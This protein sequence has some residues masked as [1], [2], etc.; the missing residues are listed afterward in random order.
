M[1]SSRSGNHSFSRDN[2]PSSFKKSSNK[3]T[4]SDDDN[5]SNNSYNRS[6]NTSSNNS[7]TPFHVV[8]SFIQRLLQLL[9]NSDN[10]S[11]Y[12]ISSSQ[13]S[14]TQLPLPHL[15][16]LKNHFHIIHPLHLLIYLSPT[17][18]LR[19]SSPPH[20]C[21]RDQVYN[22][23]YTR[24]CASGGGKPARLYLID[25]ARNADRQDRVLEG[26]KEVKGKREKKV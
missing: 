5:Y 2:S 10:K 20:P 23:A 11:P 24:A 18:Q 15:Q 6:F 8:Y 21:F 14:S 12:S 25:W 22:A 7:R 1:S 17:R 9:Q 19:I 26:I 3:P 16:R 4:S 13:S